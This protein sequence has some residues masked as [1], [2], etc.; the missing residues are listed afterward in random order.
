MFKFWESRYEQALCGLAVLSFIALLCV[1]IKFAVPEIAKQAWLE[2]LIRVLQSKAFEDIAGDLL[3][4]LVAAY[5]FY[6][7]IDVVPRVKRAQA[8]LGVL[9]MVAGSVVHSYQT[10]HFFGHSMAI[11]QV[12]ADV[13]AADN[14]RKLLEEVKAGA[15]Y[16]KLKCALFTA[17][18]RAADFQNSLVVAAALDTSRVL[19]WL[20][21]CDK[22]RLLSDEYLQ[23]P[24]SEHFVP[25]QV[26][27]PNAEI[28]LEGRHEEFLDYSSALNLYRQGLQL[29]VYEFLEEILRWVDPASSAKAEPTTIDPNVREIERRL[30]GDR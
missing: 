18:S 26:F 9:N 25:S 30:V 20:V 12:G 1:K 6:L 14:L 29:C 23:E 4:G 13:L 27:N 28:D 11:T 10:T 5:V 8:S 22:V 24:Q 2:G 15:N 16:P 7:F 21:I 17:H 19:Q 3:T